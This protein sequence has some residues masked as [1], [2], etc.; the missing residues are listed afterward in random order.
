MQFFLWASL[1][2]SVFAAKLSDQEEHDIQI[3][4][5]DLLEA[6]TSAPQLKRVGK[7]T[8][9][10]KDE[11]LEYYALLGCPIIFHGLEKPPDLSWE[12]VVSKF[13]SNSMRIRQPNG[14]FS[15]QPVGEYITNMLNEQPSGT[16]GKVTYA[17][18]IKHPPLA[19]WLGFGD[20]SRLPPFLYYSAKGDSRTDTKH[21][22]TADLIG[23]S[24]FWIGP[25][26][27]K[28][29]RNQKRTNKSLRFPV[30]CCFSSA[31]F[32]CRVFIKTATIT[33]CTSP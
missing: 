32:L 6:R 1:A 29:V 7:I 22:S 25:V 17:A 18:G 15:P 23:Q 33:S 4:F 10:T 19:N 31:V 3:G 9:P 5:H 24:N 14:K 20:A 2:T 30:A 28:T 16:S 8:L 12:T 27:S 21:P 26:G 11:F 13:G